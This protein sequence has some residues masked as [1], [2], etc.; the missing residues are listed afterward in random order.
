MATRVK[1]KVT[2]LADGVRIIE[3][4]GLLNTD[5]GEWSVV[6]FPGDKCVHAYGT[7]GA[8]G[9]VTI[10]GTNETGAPAQ[11]QTLHDPAA[12]VLTL[13]DAAG[14]RLKQCLESPYQIRPVV[15]AGDG[16]T[17]LTVRL[18]VVGR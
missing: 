18:C 6:P 5:D 3:W 8:G 14:A 10:Q 1:A 9:T 13:T 2:V 11:G 17:S 12:A 4:A 15:T 16:T 7:F